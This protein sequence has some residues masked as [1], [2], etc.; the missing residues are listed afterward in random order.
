MGQF[1][2]QQDIDA[3]ALAAEAALL[4]NTPKVTTVEDGEQPPL[5]ENLWNDDDG[6]VEE[7]PI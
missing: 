1:D 3:A 4:D 7:V 5:P 2:Q 6:V